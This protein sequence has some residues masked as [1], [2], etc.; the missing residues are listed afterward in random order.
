[1]PGQTAKLDAA[2]RKAGYSEVHAHTILELLYGFTPE[3][4]REPGTYMVL[5]DYLKHSQAAVRELAYWHLV[6]L[7]PAGKSI[8]YDPT[9]SAAERQRGYEAWRDLIPPG[10][11]PPAKK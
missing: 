8:E 6:R 5:I 7:A 9:A 4:R 2:L 11:L 10:K 1:A 3:Q